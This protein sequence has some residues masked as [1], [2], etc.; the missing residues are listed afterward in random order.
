MK[1][2]LT[3]LALFCCL[4][5]IAQDDGFF[6]PSAQIGHNSLFVTL[7]YRKEYTEGQFTF[8]PRFGLAYDPISD[9]DHFY[10]QP[11]VLNYHG[12]QIAPFW[13]RSYRKSIGYQVPFS[14][15]YKFEQIEIW[16]NYVYHNR[17]LDVHFVFNLVN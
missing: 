3:L 12:F 16:A 1:S 10:F 11:L 7:D 17:S 4:P 8:G 13:L 6:V 14:A 2:I 9:D 5:C 15:S